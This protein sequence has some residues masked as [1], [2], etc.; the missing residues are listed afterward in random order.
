MTNNADAP[1]IHIEA[2]RIGSLRI[3][4][5]KTVRQRGISHGVR[6]SDMGAPVGISVNSD[7]DIAIVRNCVLHAV[8]CGDV[9]CHR[10]AAERFWFTDIPSATFVD[11]CNRLG[12]LV[13]IEVLILLVGH[14]RHN[15]QFNTHHIIH[16]QILRPLHRFVFRIGQ[17]AHRHNDAHG[18]RCCDH[19]ER[20]L[21][22]VKRIPHTLFD[23]NFTERQRAGDDRLARHTARKQHRG[24]GLDGALVH[25]ADH[26]LIAG[27]F[28]VAAEQC[29]GEPQHGVEPVGRQQRKAQRLPPVVMPRKMRP[30]MR[31]YILPL[32]L[33]QTG[34][35][36]DAWFY[37]AEDERR[38]NGITKV[39]IFL[40]TERYA[41]APAQPKITHERIEQHDSKADEPHP[42]REIR[43]HIE[44]VDACQ[45][46]G[47]KALAQRRVHRVVDE[48]HAARDGR[49]GIEAHDLGAEGLRAR[50]QAQRA[51][52]G[53]RQHQAQ[54]DHAP[55]QDI[56]PLG[57]APQH[58]AQCQHRQHE[59]ACGNAQI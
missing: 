36:V 13:C 11:E 8:S 26:P 31:E 37:N 28:N 54:R 29:I 58:Q 17:K 39:D 41:H 53:E 44:R 1:I 23:A 16:A 34:G 7:I 45:R 57:G 33:V 55:E 38:G 50:D 27:Q 15:R 52:D 9:E 48:L 10:T 46:R 35:Q 56:H 51:L 49:R 24:I 21:F 40:H 22:V 3:T 47:G 25:R 2:V 59:P 12:N 20:G 19:P 18:D 42:A 30:L 6:P 14:L 5:L 43:P 4:D 32:H